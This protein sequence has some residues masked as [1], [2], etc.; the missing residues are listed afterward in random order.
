MPRHVPPILPTLNRPSGAIQLDVLEL[1]QLVIDLFE[2]LNDHNLD[3]WSGFLSDDFVGEQPGA[4]GPTNREQTRAYQQT[5]ITAFPDLTFDFGRIIAEGDFAVVDWKATGRHDGPLATP[6][7]QTIPPTKKRATVY[8][9]TTFKV[10]ERKIMRGWV[11]W[12][13]MTLLAQLGLM[14][15]A[16]AATASAQAAS[17]S[18][19]ARPAERR[20]IVHVEIPAA[21]REAAASFYNELFGWEFEHMGA[22]T[23]YT[24]FVTGNIGGGFPDVGEL[25]EPCDELVYLY[26]G[27]IDT[28][29]RGIESRGGQTVMPS[30]EI[31]GFG[32]F[33]IFTDPTGNRLALYTPLQE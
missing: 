22:P 31:P 3:T 4:P 17:Q 24:T 23:N 19:A 32:W 10:A 27:D 21:D 7:G 20:G 8:G 25:Y 5:F 1:K 2:A 28:D 29:L 30:T 9:S 33:A 18:A 12:D 11:Y 15:E 26:S 14:P 16:G 13:M 6:D